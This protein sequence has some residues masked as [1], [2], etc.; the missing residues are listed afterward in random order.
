MVMMKYVKEN[1][2]Y[3]F[4]VFNLTASFANSF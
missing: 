3:F 4:L 2:M 1:L